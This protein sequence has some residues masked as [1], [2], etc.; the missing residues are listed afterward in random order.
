MGIWLNKYY[1]LIILPDKIIAYIKINQ[2]ESFKKTTKFRYFI[3]KYF[4]KTYHLKKYKLKIIL[5]I[6]EFIRKKHQQLKNN[7][8]MIKNVL[9]KSS[10]NSSRN[11]SKNP[12]PRRNFFSRNHFSRIPQTVVT[13]TQTMILQPKI[14]HF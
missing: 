2:L 1:L 3:L 9:K 4:L 14:I 11:S 13:L 10:R 7:R 8:K 12:F 5:Q 6:I